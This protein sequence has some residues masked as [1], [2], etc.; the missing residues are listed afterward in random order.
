MGRLD[1]APDEAPQSD[2][3]GQLQQFADLHD[4][5]ALSDDE[6]ASAIAKLLES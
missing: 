2:L 6:F 1:P 3:T 4:Q 5:G